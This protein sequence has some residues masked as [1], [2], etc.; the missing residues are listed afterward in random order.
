MGKKTFK[1][2]TRAVAGVATGGLSEIALAGSN[3][4]KPK[5]PK[6]PAVP[7]LDQE[8]TTLPDEG[9]TSE[10]AERIRRRARAQAATSGRASTILTSPLGLTEPA[11][12]SRRLLLGR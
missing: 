9:A 3:A 11:P 8:G 1:P 10:A 2:I 4:F 5:T 6:P 12:T 7:V